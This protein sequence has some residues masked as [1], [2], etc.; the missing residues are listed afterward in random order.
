MIDVKGRVGTMHLDERSVREFC[1]RHSMSWK[2]RD[3]QRECMKE[4]LFELLGSPLEEEYKEAVDV[5]VT[6][7]V[8]AQ[9]SGFL[10]KIEEEFERKM[11]VNNDKPIRIGFGK[12]QK[13]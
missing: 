8:Y 10:H 3:M 13:R 6:V 7:L 2:D 12:V 11:A 9:I 1:N 5:I 4:E